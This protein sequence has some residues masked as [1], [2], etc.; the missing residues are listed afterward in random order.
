MILQLTKRQLKSG[1]SVVELKGSIHSGADC[2]RIE[3][4]VQ[5]LINEQNLH[6]IFDMAGLT[7]IDSAAIGSIVRCFSSLKKA[8]GDLRLAGAKGMLQGTLKLTK[9]DSVIG[10]FETT[11]EAAQNFPPTASPHAN[12]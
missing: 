10:L 3:R 9:V 5:N 6:V 7:H 1:L 11:A 8:N 4:E 2:R 12:P